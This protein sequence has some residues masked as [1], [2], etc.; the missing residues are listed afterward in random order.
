MRPLAVGVAVSGLL[1]VSVPLLM[2]PAD[3]GEVHQPEAAGSSDAVAAVSQPASALQQPKLQPPQVRRVA[4]QIA[5]LPQIDPATLERVEAPRP[6]E[7]AAA[8]QQNAHDPSLK[9]KLLYRPLATGAGSFRAQGYNVT[10]AGLEPT[11]SDETCGNDIDAWPCGIH[12]RTAFRNWLRGRALTCIGPATPPEGGTVAAD[13]RLGN[14]D[15]AEWLVAQGWA[16]AEPDG[17]F[18]VLG[19]TAQQQRRGLFG[20]APVATLPVTS[21]PADSETSGG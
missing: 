4:P 16:R 19:E 14:Q 11:G 10:L 15:P 21:A 9:E 6:P 12:A 7:Q 2:V 18:A 20:S 3:F 13:C 1:R 5:G 17:P 8:Q